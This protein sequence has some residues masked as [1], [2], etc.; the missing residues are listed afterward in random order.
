[1]SIH[2]EE[3][4]AQEGSQSRRFHCTVGAYEGTAIV[5]PNLPEIVNYV[6]QGAAAPRPLSP[7]KEAVRDYMRQHPA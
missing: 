7:L 1:M 4:P 6:A 2:I 3:L 5:N